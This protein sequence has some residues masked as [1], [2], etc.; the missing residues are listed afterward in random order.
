MGWIP[1]AGSDSDAIHDNVAGE[2]NALTSVTPASGDFVLI[3][4]ASDSYEKKKVDVDD[5]GGGG[6]SGVENM[7]GAYDIE[8]D[9]SPTYTDAGLSDEFAS[10]TL[11]GQ[12]TAVGMSSGTVSLLT[13]NPTDSVYDLSTRPGSLLVQV[14]PADHP[15]LRAD[16]FIASGEQIIASI[17]VA[18]P[19]D[20]VPG[21]NTMWA[22]V[23]YNDDDTDPYA[24]N[25]G[26]LFW[27]GADD[28]RVVFSANSGATGFG[29]IN[30]SAPSGSRAYFRLVRDSNTIY[31]YYSLDGSAWSS[32]NSST[33]AVSTAN[34]FWLIFDCRA[35]TPDFAPILA[36]NWVRH[37]ANQNLDPW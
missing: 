4:D 9:G 37:V 6:S 26:Q 35:G 12:W 8:G 3:E 28:D 21:G 34:N 17:S 7:T 20:T 27:D 2:I 32:L 14:K 18:H 33:T 1:K 36:V 10:G 16:S 15:F 29:I 22:G 11:D 30:N 13:A 5:L 24:G 23:G 25:D 19:G 31:A